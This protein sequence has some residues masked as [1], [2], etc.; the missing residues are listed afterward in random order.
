MAAA[1][2][3]T[4]RPPIRRRGDTLLAAIYAAVLEELATSGYAALSIERV[5][6]RAHTG[7]ASI[8]RRWPSRLELVL[9]ALDQ[10]LPSMDDLPDTGS[11]REDLLVVLR[12]IAAAMSSREGDAARACFGP[13]VDEELSEAIRQRLLGPRKSAFLT[14]LRR[15]AARGDISA[16]AVTPRIAET[17]PM[18]L[19]GELLQRG[20]I[21]DGAVVEIVDEVLL[22][23]LRAPRQM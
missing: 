2:P 8:Y 5:A 23:L 6:E 22:P 16:G 1:D 15:A 4:R 18:L 9:D 13:G 10:T 12:R 11:I 7:K 14:L 20:A 21:T 17:G 3:L 19:H